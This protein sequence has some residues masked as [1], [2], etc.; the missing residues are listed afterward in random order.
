MAFNLLDSV[1]GLFNR[2][3]IAKASNMLGENESNVQKAV[4]GIVPTVLAGIMNKAASGDAGSVL[5]MAKDAAGSGVLSNSESFF[6]SGNLFNKGA[7][8]LKSLFGGRVN[9]AVNAISE[10]S[11]IR[12]AS[13]ASLMGFAAPVA[14]GTLGQQATATNMSTS[15]LLSFLS[16]QKDSILRAIPSGLNLAGI[17]G[18]PSLDS[19]GNKLSGALSSIGASVKHMSGKISEPVQKSG[20]MRWALP[21]ILGLAALI[22]ILYLMRKKDT[23]PNTVSTTMTDTMETKTEPVITTT[24]PTVKVT[25]PNGTELN[26]YRGG[27]ED[28]LV[29]YLNDPNMKIDKNKWFDFDNLNFETNSATITP[30]SMTQVQN[31]AAILKAY[32]SITIKIGGYTDKTGD[33][34]ANLKLSQDR[35]NATV[36]ALKSA[37]ADAS[38]IAGAEGYGSAFAKAAPDAPDSEKRLDR[39]ISVNVRKK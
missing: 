6:G 2:D 38:Q 33:D 18:L 7:D 36:A 26:A 5:S 30:E 23:T 34:M 3:L 24:I 19:I 12:P 15:G 11:G 1:K 20:A 10:N 25:L 9:E 14:L 27:I 13:A 8:M 39:R 28:Q 21:V 29:A 17:L 22:L 31:I 37:G 4:S 35:A 16:D 32:P